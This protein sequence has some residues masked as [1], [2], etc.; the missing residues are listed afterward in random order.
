VNVQDGRVLDVEESR[1]AER[2]SVIPMKKNGGLNQRWKIVYLDE[3]KPEPTTGL[4][5]DFGFYR[6]SPFYMSSRLG[7]HRVITTTTP[8]SGGSLLI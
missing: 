7:S 4:D 6:N 2:T 5:E 3:M 1:D 8:Y